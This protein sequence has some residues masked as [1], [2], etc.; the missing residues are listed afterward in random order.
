MADRR[1]TRLRTAAAEWQQVELLHRMPW[2]AL[3]ALVAR[4]GLPDRHRA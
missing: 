2:P 4:T 1:I 3:A